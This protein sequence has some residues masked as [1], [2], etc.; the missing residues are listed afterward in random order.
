MSFYYCPLEQFIIL[1]FF[2]KGLFDFVSITNTL[3]TFLIIILLIFIY[4]S[5]I[6]SRENSLLFIIPNP[7]VFLFKPLFNA[8]YLIIS[9]NLNF[10]GKARY[11]P[12]IGTIFLL[13]LIL[14]LFGMNPYTYTI[15]SQPIITFSIGLF[16]FTGIQIISIKKN[17][18]NFFSSFFPSGISVILGLLVIPI[19]FMSFL[20]KPLSLSVRLFINMFAG[21]VLLKI[22]A[23]FAVSILSLFG[24]GLLLHYLILIVLV[25]LYFMEIAASIIQA[26][27]FAGLLCVYLNEVFSTH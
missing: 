19:E 25:A 27:V 7:W 12:I 1:K 15:T 18:I 5:G 14:N 17:K 4:I 23:S 11:F 24:V 16:A 2:G 22:A 8:V 20:F 21:H 6:K 3:I 10:E 13:V 26:A 9:Q